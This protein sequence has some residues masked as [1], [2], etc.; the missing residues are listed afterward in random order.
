M[1]IFLSPLWVLRNEGILSKE[2]EN[3]VTE[4]QLKKVEKGYRPHDAETTKTRKHRLP[5]PLSL[6]SQKK[7]G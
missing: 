4:Q 6:L 2:T 1:G 5:S 3:K 7:L